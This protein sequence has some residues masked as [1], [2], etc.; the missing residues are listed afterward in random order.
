[1]YLHYSLRCKILLEPFH[2]CVPHPHDITPPNS[3]IVRRYREE[4]MKRSKVLGHLL[5][6]AYQY[7]YEKCWRRYDTKGPC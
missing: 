7:G 2:L 3:S 4:P 5:I 1:M 6:M